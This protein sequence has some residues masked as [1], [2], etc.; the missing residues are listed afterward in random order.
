MKSVFLLVS[1]PNYITIAKPI[2][3]R[4]TNM[5]GS[6][7]FFP[8]KLQRKPFLDI[9]F[10][11]LIDTT[12]LPNWFRQWWDYFGCIVELLHPHLMVEKGYKFFK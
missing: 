1:K 5:H 2:P 7:P 11:N 10:D 3:T 12:K 4:T 6:M 9:L 8:P